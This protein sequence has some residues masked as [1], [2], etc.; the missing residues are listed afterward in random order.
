MDVIFKSD[1]IE[2]EN[3]RK[4][5]KVYKSDIIDISENKF[6]PYSTDIL[7]KGFEEPYTV[8]LSYHIFQHKMSED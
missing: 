8:N 6:N 5:V 1:S 2:F 4:R 7:V 3:A